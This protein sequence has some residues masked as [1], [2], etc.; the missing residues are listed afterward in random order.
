MGDVERL[1]SRVAL[2][3][4]HARDL[5]G[6][7]N[8][9]ESLPALRTALADAASPRL[10]ELGSALEELGGV[11]ALL[12][13]ALVDDPPLGLHEGRLLRPGVSQEL[14][15]LKAEIR[16]AQEWIAGLEPRGGPRHGL[17]PPPGPF[18]R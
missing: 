15:G 11:Q 9:L 7:R 16:G 5:I 10:R 12:A 14:G 8:S 2:G 1:A 18:P 13:E 17:P 3:L 6:L 4:A